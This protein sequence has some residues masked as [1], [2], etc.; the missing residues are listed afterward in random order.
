ML[1]QSLAHLNGGLIGSMV[2][3]STIHRHVRTTY[4]QATLSPAE[5]GP[6]ATSGTSTKYPFAVS[7]IAILSSCQKH[8]SLL[9]PPL[10]IR[11][12]S[13]QQQSPPK[14]SVTPLH[15]SRSLSLSTWSSKQVRALPV[16]T[17]RPKRC[18]K[19]PDQ[20]GQ[21]ESQRS[22][23]TLAFTRKHSNSIVPRKNSA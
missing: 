19:L 11:P 10:R 4:T 16:L 22:L 8:R 21:F 17:H 2:G 6:I 7:T 20:E 9:L 14:L 12:I 5:T 13:H 1:T 15:P 23:R 3:S 18:S